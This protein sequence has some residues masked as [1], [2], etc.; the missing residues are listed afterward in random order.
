MKEY[1]K[2]LAESII[3]IWV[4]TTISVLLLGVLVILA[5]WPLCI[6]FITER[7]IWLGMLV[8]TIPWAAT[9]VSDIIDF[10]RMKMNKEE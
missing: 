2:H 1:I 4:Y 3:G 6:V 10:I 7:S 8:V 5:L 9:T